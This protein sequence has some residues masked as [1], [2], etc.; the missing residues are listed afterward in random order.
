ML[1]NISKEEQVAYGLQDM[2]E[3]TLYQGKGCEKCSNTGYK[4]RIALYEVVEVNDEI[5]DI[6]AE[7]SANEALI[8]EAAGRQNMLTMK[9]D[10]ILK[11]L[12]GITTLAEIERVT[13]GALVT[14]DIE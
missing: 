10:G 1:R 13:E 6:I 4:G 14:L 7:K 3:V 5:H 2:K 8:I 11:V 9:E 12:K